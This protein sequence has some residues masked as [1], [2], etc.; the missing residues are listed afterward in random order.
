MTTTTTELT[1]KVEQIF[2][3]LY[4]LD[5]TVR[6][7][8]S[9]EVQPN[10]LVVCYG[11]DE[12]ESLCVFDLSIANSLSAALPRI[13]KN[14]ASEATKAGEFPDNL[15]ANF[16]EIANIGTVM[17]R[18]DQKQRIELKEILGPAGD[19]PESIQELLKLPG[20]SFELE[21]GDYDPGNLKLIFK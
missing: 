13:H 12:V 19:L 21:V 16:D 2:S 3:S 5:F 20:A 10:S 11:R 15:R 1:S 18:R 6:E 4:D 17:M 7:L 14:I 9:S 8:E